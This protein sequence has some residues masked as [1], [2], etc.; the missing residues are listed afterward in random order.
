MC[1]IFG[2]LTDKYSDYSDETIKK[3]VDTLFILSESRGKEA[4]GLAIKKDNIIF[5]F[6]QAI[7]ASKLIKSKK[8]KELI[9]Q[10]LSTDGNTIDNKGNSNSLAI[11]GHSR[12]VTDGIQDLNVNNQPIIK[13]GAVAIHNGIIVNN[14]KLWGRF[15]NMQRIYEVD[16]E[17]ILSMLQMFRKE[18]KSII[19]AAQETFFHIE[20]SASIG[21]LFN[22]NNQLLLATNTGSLYIALNQSNTLCAFASE[23]YILSQLISDRTLKKLW[24]GSTIIHVKHGSGYIVNISNLEL[25]PFS[26]TIKD[27]SAQVI[28]EIV[29]NPVDI[30]D[31][32]DAGTDSAFNSDPRRPRVNIGNKKRILNEI[33]RQPRPEVDLRRCTKCILPETFPFIEFDDEGVCNYCRNYKKNIVKGPNVLDD[34]VSKYRSQNGEPDCLIGLSGGRDS[35]YGLHY[36]KNVL[37]MNPIAF[38]YDWGMVTDLARRNMS[39]ICSKLGVEHII[40]SADITKKRENIRKNIKAWLKKPELGMVPLFMAG[41]K[42]FLYYAHEVMKQTNVKLVFG[43]FTSL[44]KTDFKTGFCGIREG[45]TKGKVLTGHSLSTKL[46]L[47]S[48]YMK[49]YL[50]NPAYIN[51]SMMDTMSAYYSTYILPDAHTYIY[52]YIPWDEQHIVSTLREE[53][54]WEFATDTTA[55]WR[56]GDGTAPFYNYIYH[57]VAGFSEFDTFRSNQIREGMITRDEALKLVQEEN[58]PRYESLEWYAQTIGFNLE[59]AIDVIHSIPKT[60]IS[61]KR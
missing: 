14:E 24:E 34:L 11:I 30:M 26:L 40:V 38:T 35:S 48:Y 10:F 45:D 13:D 36:I 6:K 19:T 61:V 43:W 15:T 39:R 46:K 29:N 4:S 52:G 51:S 3:V 49:Q 8:Y 28:G 32:S 16:T 17:V 58:M 7:P 53:Y 44:E 20:G 37:K 5:V 1:G 42:Q 47:I 50:F 2:L 23:K 31:L 59:D 41:D 60:Y 56:I 55:T 54:N 21:V 18:K 12:L 25:N 33:A 57:T 22:D 27:D 9:Q